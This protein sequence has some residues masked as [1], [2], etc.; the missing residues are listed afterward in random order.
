MTR[1]LNGALIAGLVA[2]GCGTPRVP[3]Q[4]LVGRWHKVEPEQSLE[5]I[6][7]AYGVKPEVIAE[8]NDVSEGRLA[9]RDEIFVPTRDGR[10]PG[11]RSRASNRTSVLKKTATRNDAARRPDST[12]K[13]LPQGT[14]E[15][16]TQSCLEW[17]V[18]GQLIAAFGPR[19]G[20]HHDGLDIAAPSGAPIV[21]ADSGVVIYSGDEIKGYGNL[22][23]L[24]H[25]SGLITVYA[26]NAHNKVSQG[27]EVARGQ[28]IATVGSTGAA[29]RDHLH[30]EVRTAQNP[31]DPL[32]LLP[33]RS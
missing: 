3:P 6:S 13:A 27:Q 5:K 14:C 28:V 32:P 33:P 12:E 25:D 15:E 29:T 31:R 2:V 4:P 30:F 24:R 7:R 16:K 22:V 17:P 1:V 21:A 23:I 18:S 9:Q 20:S 10:P 8:L 26:H 19:Q 11:A